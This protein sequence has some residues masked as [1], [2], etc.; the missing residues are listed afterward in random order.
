MVDTRQQTSH[1]SP[2]DLGE[3]AEELLEAILVSL[4]LEL[5]GCV[6]ISSFFEPVLLL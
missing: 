2:S 5:S 4:S 6:N 3:R 1:T